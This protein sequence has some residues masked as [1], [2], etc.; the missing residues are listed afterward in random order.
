MPEVRAQ[1][2]ADREAGIVQVRDVRRMIQLIRADARRLPLADGSIDMI[3]SDPPYVK[4][5][6]HTYQYIA[7]EAARILRPG[8]FVVVMAATTAIN[9]IMRWF[10]DAGLSYYWL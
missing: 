9:R 10:D 2:H 3:F 7:D 6:V 4:E 5:F 1:R 8:G